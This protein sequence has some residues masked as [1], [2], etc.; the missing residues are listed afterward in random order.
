MSAENRHAIALRAAEP[1][2]ED[3]VACFRYVD[4]AAEG[5]FGFLLGARGPDIVAK[6]FLE[7][8]HDLSYENVVFAERDGAV[9]GMT[10]GYTAE[11][12]RRSSQAPL[13][14]AA[15][16]RTLRMRILFAIFGPLMRITDSLA[17]GDLYLQSI[18]VDP[19]L[20]GEGVGSILMDAFEE[21]ARVKGMSRSS[22]DVSA[23]NEGARRLYERGGWT[24]ESQWPKRIPLPG[25]KLYRMV[26]PL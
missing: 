14:R 25:L 17:D 24:V 4:Q 10:L 13:Y 9:V 12:H 8:G 20:R 16:G 11:Q 3:G 2:Y 1:A 7:R 15:D 18:A 21:Q 6:A 22:L 23:S 19:E 5:F 26:K